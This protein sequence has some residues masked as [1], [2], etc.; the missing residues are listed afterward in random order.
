MSWCG[1]GTFIFFDM[2]VCDNSLDMAVCSDKLLLV[3]EGPSF[4]E[5]PVFSQE[6]AQSEHFAQPVD[7]NRPPC[8]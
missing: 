5:M 6:C 2:T 7:T 8:H 1:R 3:E 4:V